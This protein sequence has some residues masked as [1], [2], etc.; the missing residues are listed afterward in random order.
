MLRTP[1]AHTLVTTYNPETSCPVTG[2]CHTHTLKTLLMCKKQSTHHLWKTS[3][4][5]AHKHT[6]NIYISSQNYTED[7]QTHLEENSK[8]AKKKIQTHNTPQAYDLL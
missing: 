3:F 8:D 5:Q 2:N 6:Q 4:S 7:T 1:A